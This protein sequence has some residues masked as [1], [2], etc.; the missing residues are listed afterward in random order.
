MQG[1]NTSTEEGP[2]SLPE[3]LPYLCDTGEVINDDDDDD[4]HFIFQC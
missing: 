2:A 4:G 1:Q 3:P